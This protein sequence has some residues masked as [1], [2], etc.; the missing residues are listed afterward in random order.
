[1][2]TPTTDRLMRCYFAERFEL[3]AAADVFDWIAST[4]ARPRGGG[5]RS[6]GE[7]R[8]SA[9]DR[10]RRKAWLLVTYGDGE[11]VACWRCG[12]PLIF[13]ML[14]VDRVVPGVDGGRYV[15]SNIR[16]ACRSCNCRAGA[17]LRYARNAAGQEFMDE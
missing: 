1:M 2:R 14:T 8:G 12:A 17:V 13:G 4:N 3:V 16:P 10:R 5:P 15:R 9:Q 7:M 6:G 11:T